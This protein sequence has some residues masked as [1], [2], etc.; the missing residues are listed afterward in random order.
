MERERRMSLQMKRLQILGL[1]G[2]LQKVIRILHRLGCVQIDEITDAP[3]VVARPLTLDR[4]TLRAQEELSL[5]VARIEGLIETMEIEEP[6]GAKTRGEATL[7]QAQAGVQELAPLVQSLAERKQALEDEEAALPRYEETLERL[8]P[9]LPAKGV[10][11]GNATIGLM[12]DREHQVALDS[13]GNRLLSLTGGRGEILATDLDSSTRAMLIVFPQ[14][15][16]S[17]LEELVDRED[18]ARLRLPSQL[19]HAPPDVAL[20]ALEERM[21]AIPEELKALQGE[22]ADL[23]STWGERLLSWKGALGE[24]LQRY[25]VLPSLGETEQTFVLVGWIPARDIERLRSALMEKMGHGVVV[26]TLP[27]TRE[28][29]KRVPIALHNIAPVRPF[30]SLVRMLSL[31]R[32]GEIDPSGLMALFLPLIF[33][34]ILGDMG[35]GALLLIISLLAML[36]FKKGTIHDILIVLAAGSAWAIFFGFLYGEAFG[37]LGE[38][39][40]LHAI[41]I[42]R[43]GAEDVGALLVM[44]IAVGAVHITLG[45]ILGVIEAIKHRSRN[46]LLERGGMLVGLIGLFMMVGV[47]VKFLPQ[48]F[49]TPGVAV[50]IVGIVLVGA[51]LGCLGILMGPIEFIGLIGNI[52]SY[53][54]IAA[55]GLASV[56]LAKVA[57]DMA[58]ML[59]NILVGGIVAVLLHAMNL[60]LG[61]FSPTIHS[62]RLHYV[63]FFRKFYEGG[64]RAYKPFRSEYLTET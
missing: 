12:V 6:K 13:I 57:N 30:E 34:M 45:L 46:H 27:I 50:L 18:V 22:M 5:L 31:P 20:H 61:A 37:T 33:G 39:L 35:Y 8:L 49:M 56:Y 29:R 2:D 4:E 51:S 19:G 17:Q 44:T 47:M 32:F 10:G 28:L 52:L 53:L 63:E 9:L 7:E 1:K 58:G 11:A 40:G 38:H 21:S 26:N 41:W 15:F 64:G 48:G 25:D 59:G 43:A 62:L 36:K 54:R 60:V 42:D 55:I 14:E 16:G 24:E 23:V 3:D